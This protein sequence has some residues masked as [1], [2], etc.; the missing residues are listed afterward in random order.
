MQ[1]TEK[2]KKKEEKNL[3]IS[4]FLFEANEDV[5]WLFLC[6]EVASEEKHIINMQSVAWP[7]LSAARA[8]PWRCVVIRL[9]ASNLST[10]SG[11]TEQMGEF[12]M[13]LQWGD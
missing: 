2:E 12:V 5:I 7:H 6:Y 10:G 1:E 13:S 3:Q 4:V 8:Q 9:S 11:S